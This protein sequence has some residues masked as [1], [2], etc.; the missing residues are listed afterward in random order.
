MA[1]F[2]VL[3]AERA[4]CRVLSPWIIIEGY[5]ATRVYLGRGRSR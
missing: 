4:A 3:D 2:N 1:T 5:A